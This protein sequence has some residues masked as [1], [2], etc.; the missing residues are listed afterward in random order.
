MD[1]DQVTRADGRQLTTSGSTSASASS[2]G[3]IGAGNSTGPVSSS[4]LN[5][6]SHL[7][8]DRA[9]RSEMSEAT[10][11]TAKQ[12]ES[13]KGIGEESGPRVGADPGTD[14]PPELGME[15]DFST[16]TDEQKEALIQNRINTEMGRETQPGT[17]QCCTLFFRF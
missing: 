4:L 6:S 17:G 16:L 12:M 15:V 8:S 2:I 14:G 7:R 5:L 3:V 9:D 10:G 1:V 11:E 13:Q